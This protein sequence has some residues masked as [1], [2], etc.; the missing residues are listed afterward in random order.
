MSNQTLSTANAAPVGT[1][2]ALDAVI[3]SGATTPSEAIFLNNIVETA[4]ET[5][6]GSSVTLDGDGFTLTGSSTT[7]ALVVASNAEVFLGDL[8]INDGGAGAISIG[9]GG[10][11]DFLP[12]HSPPTGTTNLGIIAGAISG[13]GAVVVGSDTDVAPADVPLVLNAANSYTGDTTIYD[14]LDLGNNGS[15]ADS[16]SV[17][18][19]AAAQ[20]F[21]VLDISGA[22]SAAGAPVVETVNNLSGVAGTHIYLGQNGLNIV[23]S[24]STTYAGVI[25]D[26]IASNTYVTSG[27]VSIAAAAGTTFTLTRGETYTGG[28]KIM[29]GTLALTGTASIAASANVS[30]KAAGATLDL[31]GETSGV[32]IN[33]LTGVA[34]SLVKLG[35]NDLTIYENVTAASFSGV[36]SGTA[37]LILYGPYELSLG[38]ANTYTGATVIQAGATLGVTGAGSLATSGISGAGALDISTATAPVTITNLA[39]QGA[40]TLGAGTLVLEGASSPSGVIS[41]TG[42]V[43]VGTASVSGS[44]SL[45][46][47][48]TYTGATKIYGALT[49][50]YDASIADSSN[51]SLKAAGASLTTLSAQSISEL[52]GVAGTTVDLGGNLTIT[53]DV[54]AATFGGVISGDDNV[55]LAAATT[56]STYGLTF[57]AAQTYTGETIIDAGAT[58]GFSGAGS[59]ADSIA[60]NDDG[61][62]NISGANPGEMTLQKFNGDGVLI[63]GSNTVE[64]ENGYDVFTGAI[65][66]SGGV[67]I[68]DAFLNLSGSASAYTGATQVDAD[69]E[70]DISAALDTSS[71]DLVASNSYLYLGATNQ[72]PT[73]FTVSQVISGAGNVEIDETDESAPYSVTLTAANTYTG[74][75]QISEYTTL[76]LSGSGSIND[77]GQ[78][79]NSGTINISGASGTIILANYDDDDTPG[80]KIVLGPNT[81]IFEGTNVGDLQTTVISGT[82]AV[83]VGTTTVATGLEF[84]QAQTYTGATKI[85]GGLY[86][87]GSGSIASSSNVSLKGADALFDI[88][89]VTETHAAP[90]VVINTL[91]GVAGSEVYLGGNTL[92]IF[93]N[94]TA[95]F[96][97]VIEGNNTDNGL[98]IDGSSYLTLAGVNTLEGSITIDKGAGLALSGLGSFADLESGVTDNGV[99]N[100]SGATF[101]SMALAPPPAVAAL[102]QFSGAGSLI[103]GASTADFDGG[104]DT[105][106][107]GSISGSG[108]IEVS[109][110]TYIDIS[111]SN[112]YTGATTIND[113]STLDVG[114]ALASS[115]IALTNVDTELEIGDGAEASV[116]ISQV[117]SGVGVVYVDEGDDGLNGDS[118]PFTATLT[119]ASTYAGGTYVFEYNTLVL[120]GAGS[121]ADSA[122]VENNGGVID[123]SQATG[124]VTLND[125]E[126][127][128]ALT[129]TLLLG[130]TTVILEGTSGYTGIDG[131]VISGTGSVQI[132][133]TTDTTGAVMVFGGP[134]AYTGSTIIYGHLEVVDT[135][136]IA[137]SSN[138]ALKVS[139][140]GLIFDVDVATIDLNSL[141]G[142]AGTTI[143]SVYGSVL[144]V[145]QDTTATFSGVISGSGGLTIDAA[146]TAALTLAGVNT[147]T[148]VTTDNGSLILGVAN[149][150][151][152]SDAVIVNGTLT[153]GVASTLNDLSGASTGTINL[154]SYALTGVL[155]GVTHY[156]YAGA[157]TGSGSLTEKGG[158]G[159]TTEESTPVTASTLT[160]SLLTLSHAGSTFTGG[161]VIEGGTVEVSAVGAAGTGAITFA[162]VSTS[163]AA[164]AG[165][166]QIDNSALTGAGTATESF[167]N[168]IA[169][170]SGQ[171]IIDLSGLT[172]DN[173]PG[174]AVGGSLSFHNGQLFVTEGNVTVALTIAGLNATTATNYHVY[175][176]AHG[177][178]FLTQITAT[179]AT[180]YHP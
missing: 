129:S 39:T 68:S 103:L 30:L 127:Q 160:T 16:S 123:I 91:T 44:A 1:E 163:V 28:T 157:I 62:L 178:T 25:A 137:S 115:G 33:E 108:G 99:L 50:S 45:S 122:A 55:E 82:G 101:N 7:P 143:S 64:I 90:A 107:S 31:S 83:Q 131:G 86:L 135:G 9:V 74:Y 97:G 100:I 59:I 149:A 56:G 12:S 19:A 121:I 88:S 72:T 134:M 18:L 81:V 84:H 138:V 42:A 21:A 93:Q 95:T 94:T 43:Q 117:I 80:A 5:I 113:S 17:T 38:G 142:V 140:A 69:S 180:H 172:Y 71:I 153:L 79:E 109:G 173:V 49:L 126:D 35:A 139:G 70:L 151:A 176:D 174:P 23:D 133:A 27:K 13:A 159:A 152:A 47:A 63:L 120:K 32:N 150:I 11:I 89:G 116:T 164:D 106:Y 14:A 29:S 3:I 105:Y 8:N 144:D 155:S 78:V 41:G 6:T 141:S 54:A 77:S 124:P 119:A 132:G 147:Y 162:D 128:D 92:D 111:G 4:P 96:S 26:S 125:Y 15:I 52:T 165:I 60:V 171:D 85:Y 118:V 170:V 73:S 110:D 58:L 154:G 36:I 65:S 179:D 75:T 76:I 37:R 177:G 51:V 87:G 112:T 169:G 57:T 46:E 130:G 61:V 48:E 168:T 34:G 40:V 2:S 161:V 136:S 175:E 24:A 20:S 148:G 114:S 158:F 156:T 167:A 10:Q 22:Q 146:S 104:N 53:E 66:G 145:T 98:I 166:L 67:E 102:D